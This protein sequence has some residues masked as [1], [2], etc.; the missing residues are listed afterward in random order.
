MW[1]TASARLLTEPL[2]ALI[3]I[4]VVIAFLQYLRERKIVWILL[5][6]LFAGLDY[7]TRPNGVFDAV[8]FLGCFVPR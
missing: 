3:L 4:W 1:R 2:Y 8:A 7:L 5:G 6:S